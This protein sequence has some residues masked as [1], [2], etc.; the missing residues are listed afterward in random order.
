MSGYRTW[1]PGEVITANAVQSFLMD[2]TV[3]VFPSA[4]VRSTAVVVPTEGMLSW[5]EAENAYQYY[6][7]ASWE[8]LIV[9]IEGGT[10]GQAYV[11]NG[12]AQAAFGDVK[13]EFISTTIQNKSANYTATASDV[14]TVLNFTSSATVTI[15]D[16][17]TAIGDRIDII[18]NTAGTVFIAAGTGVSSF[19]GGGTAG[20]GV[21]FFIHTSY[22]AASVL[23]T[24]ANEYRVIGQVSA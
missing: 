6:D 4:A 14:N 2:Q 15:P 20:G 18:R 22:A 21:V 19:A 10:T 8:D 3:M 11:S 1:T 5:N 12:T 7:G 23:K 13:A 9:P 24:G 17:A 16:V